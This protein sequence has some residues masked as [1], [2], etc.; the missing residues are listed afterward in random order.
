[1]SEYLPTIFE[2]IVTG[3]MVEQWCVE[4]AE[5]WTSTYLS[6]LERQTGTEPFY[7][8]R[9]RAYVRSISAD[10]WP[11]D[12]TPA[13]IFQMDGV[14]TPPA[15]DARG[16]YTMV[17]LVALR[18]LAA[19]ATE[20]AANELAQTLIGAQRALFLQRPTLDGHAHGVSW[21]NEQPDGLSFDD[22][23]TLS[24]LRAQLAIEVRDVVNEYGG[25]TKP[26]EPS[27]APWP[28]WPHVKTV[29][30]DVIN[31]SLS[32]TAVRGEE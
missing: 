11:E 28:A 8:A 12:Q 23:R 1:M 10:K 14:A 27:D 20:Q 22:L 30:I 17:F 6:E 3:V 15:K 21:L 19:A 18:V 4:L 16:S 24:Q 25:P 31:E 5:R 32:A 13:V 29:D 26:D 9:P 2:P 7:Y